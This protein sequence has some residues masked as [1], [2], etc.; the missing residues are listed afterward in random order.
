MFS[1]VGQRNLILQRKMLC[2]EGPL[3]LT[4]SVSMFMSVV[5]LELVK[6]ATAV[7]RARGSS[8]SAALWWGSE[9]GRAHV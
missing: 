8:T 5:F 9:I 2:E 4:E 3:S 6:I 7:F 1:N